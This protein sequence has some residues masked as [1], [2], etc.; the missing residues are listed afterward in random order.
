MNELIEEVAGAFR[1]ERS[2]GDSTLP[3][4]HDLDEAGRREAFELAVSLR[5]LRPRSSRR[6]IT[7]VAPCW[8]RS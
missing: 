7:T 3:A 6:P 4:W 2:S 1:P 8:G 5:T